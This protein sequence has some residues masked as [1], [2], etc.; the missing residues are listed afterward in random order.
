MR[1]IENNAVGVDQ[2]D[3][4]LFSDFEDDGE[5]WTGNGPRLIRQRVTFG[6]IFADNPVV[7]VT[8]SMWD[9]AH[10]TNGRVDVTSENIT[11]DGCDIVF[12]TWGDTQ[13]ARVRVAWL[14]IGT[15]R[16]ED[17]WDI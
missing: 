8:L 12:R 5:M 17:S 4:V 10:S 2:G 15:L 11:R 7:H 1:R 16:S 6:E 9:I 14:A 3:L 13:V